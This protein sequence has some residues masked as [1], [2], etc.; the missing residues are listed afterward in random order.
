MEWPLSLRR[1]CLFNEN[2]WW[3]IFITTRGRRRKWWPRC[4]AVLIVFLIFHG[5][6]KL[7]VVILRTEFQKLPLIVM[8]MGLWLVP[9]CWQT[10]G[11]EYGNGFILPIWLPSMRASFCGSMLLAC[12]LSWVNSLMDHQVELVISVWTFH[13][14]HYS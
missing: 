10:M 5:F 11:I 9:P 1:V 7:F 4:P 12:T 3:G 8:R 6:I 2:F 13:Y 14:L